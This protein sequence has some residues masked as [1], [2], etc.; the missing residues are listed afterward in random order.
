VAVLPGHAGLAGRDRPRREAARDRQDDRVNTAGMYF[1]YF[2]GPLF[3]DRKCPARTPRHRPEQSFR[4]RSAFFPVG[5]PP[6]KTG[7][8]EPVTCP[9][10]PLFPH[11]RKP[12]GTKRKNTGI[13][14]EQTRIP[15]RELRRSDVDTLQQP[16]NTGHVVQDVR[17]PGRGFSERILSRW[18][19]I[20][21]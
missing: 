5:N 18:T 21:G 20:T 19:G 9:E 1:F 4:R 13:M 3:R 16:G 6:G 14:P 11:S 7:T 8:T 15:R 2:S 10:V 12:A 17:G